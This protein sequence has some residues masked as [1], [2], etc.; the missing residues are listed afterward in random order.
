MTFFTIFFLVIFIIIALL[1]ILLVM[2][3]KEG[4]DGIG[5]MFGGNSA[6]QYGRRSGNILTRITTIL[7]ALFMIFAFSLAWINRSPDSTSVEQAARAQARDD[8]VQWWLD[9]PGASIEE[10]TTN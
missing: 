10:E 5:S 3:Q 7:G 8:Q 9:D 4:S 6:Q 2:L 1:L